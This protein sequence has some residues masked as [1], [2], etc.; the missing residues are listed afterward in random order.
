MAIN[1]YWACMELEWQVAQEPSSVSRS[2][3]KNVYPLKNNNPSNEEKSKWIPLNKC[4]AFASYLTNLYEIKSLYDIKF[5]VSKEKD[6]IISHYD[7]SFFNSK[8]QIRSI[9]KKAF[10][11]GNA[12]IFFTD[13]DS[14]E[15]TSYEY[16]RFEQNSITDSCIMI[17]GKYD[18]GKW[19]RPL[20]FAFY[21]KEDVDIFSVEKGDILY[22]I[23]FHTNEKINFKQFRPSEEIR[24]MIKENNSLQ[25]V[26]PKKIKM[27]EKFYSSFKMK[28]LVLDEIKRNLI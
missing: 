27:F 25:S 28:K 22:Y 14:L 21:L 6:K 7:E 2:F 23:K 8:I 13:E 17:P 11:L 5:H 10:S 20:E 19:F 12:F 15:I 26:L 18:I 3:F 9:E 4:P 16:P 1:V 24:N